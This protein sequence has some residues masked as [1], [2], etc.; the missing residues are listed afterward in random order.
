MIIQK[1]TIDIVNSSFNFPVKKYEQDWPLEVADRF[2]L[3][4]FVSFLK[5]AEIDAHLKY[6]VMA[7]IS[8]S[9]DDY[10]SFGEEPESEIWDEI[11]KMLNRRPYLYDELLSYWAPKGIEKEDDEFSI[12]LLIRELLKERTAL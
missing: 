1:Q 3:R 6:A 9:Y 10:I 7:L 4:E 11:K 8:A 2:R 12:T 5:H